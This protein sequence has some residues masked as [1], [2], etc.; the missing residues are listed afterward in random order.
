MDS[1]GNMTLQIV[2]YCQERAISIRPKKPAGA[3]LLKAYT[4]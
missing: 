1:V 3:L 2:I 4:P